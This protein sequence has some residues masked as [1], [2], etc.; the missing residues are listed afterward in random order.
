MSDSPSILGKLRS[1]RVTT[2]RPL[3]I[4]DIQTSGH[5]GGGDEEIVGADGFALGRQ[6]SPQTGVGPGGDQ[7]ESDH[8]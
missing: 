1:S 2:S 8:G 6:S 7:I 4:D 3:A 5:R